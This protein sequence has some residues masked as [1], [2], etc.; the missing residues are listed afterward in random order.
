MLMEEERAWNEGKKIELLFQ[1][2]AQILP[3]GLAGW[4]YTSDPRAQLIP[5]KIGFVWTI[6]NGSAGK[7]PICKK[8]KITDD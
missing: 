2:P 5:Q 6:E 4:A 1:K 8:K 3:P 7:G